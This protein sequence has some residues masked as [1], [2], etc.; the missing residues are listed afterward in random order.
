MNAFAAS[1]LE[2]ADPLAR[3]GDG[4]PRCSG[5]PPRPQLARR[6]PDMIAA[7]HEPVDVRP[8]PVAP[9]QGGGGRSAAA[10]SPGL[11]PPVTASRAE[12]I[13]ASSGHARQQRT[14]ALTGVG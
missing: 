8:P 14:P 1:D 9:P 2:A 12:M 4:G 13:A 7:A 6:D 11:H 5:G 10:G 3:P